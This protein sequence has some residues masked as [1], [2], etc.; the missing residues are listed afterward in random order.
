MKLPNIERTHEAGGKV[1][2][3]AD[4]AVDLHQALLDNLQH[5][6]SGQGI[7]EAVAQQDGERQAL[8]ALV[9][10]S[11]WLGGLQKAARVSASQQPNA[12]FTPFTTTL[13]RSR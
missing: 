6:G 3:G 5:L 13:S 7:L 12:V 10:A 4:L 8:S 9:R 11:A 1:L 2:G